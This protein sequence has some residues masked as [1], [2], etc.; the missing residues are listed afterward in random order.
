MYSSLLNIPTDQLFPYVVEEMHAVGD[1]CS[2]GPNSM[3]AQLLSNPCVVLLDAN[4]FF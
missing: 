2:F 3:A 1:I 4:N